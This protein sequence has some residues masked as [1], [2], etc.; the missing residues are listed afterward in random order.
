M[1]LHIQM[2]DEAL[3]KLKRDAMMSNVVSLGV[4]LGMLLLFGSILYFTVLIIQGEIPTEFIAYVPQSE[5]GPPTNAP[6]SRELTSK[7]VTTNP[8]VTPSVI[9]AQN[10]VGPVAA[11]VSIDTA[12]DLSFDQIDM[13][14]DMNLRDGLGTGGSGMGSGASGGSALEGTF[15]DLKLSRDGNSPSSI[16]RSE[17][18]KRVAFYKVSKRNGKNTY[19]FNVTSANA[20]YRIVERLNNFFNKGQRDALAPFYSSP[21]KLYASSFYVPMT[22]ASYA[23]HAYQCS[24]VCQ[25]AG[26]V[27]VYR[28]NVRAPKSGKFRFVGV[29]DDTLGVRFD[30]KVVLEAGYIILSLWEKDNIAGYKVSGDAAANNYWMK[31]RKGELPDKNGYIQIKTPETPTWNQELGGLTAGKVFEVKE[32]EVYPIQILVS[33]IPGGAFGYCLFIEDV[34]DMSA[35]QLTNTEQR[36]FDLFRTNF[37]SPDQKE[38]IDQ[39]RKGGA[40]LYGGRFQLPPF[41]PD[42]PIWAAVP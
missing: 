9:V 12:G 38:I 37:S 28:G 41:N 35:E 40:S 19:D 24:D 23:P 39:L 20:S 11:P 18:D 6:V 15:Y 29:G 31:V 21:Q 3:R 16:M 27:C 33:E 34:T 36:Q 7:S 14:M 1:S 10:A 32:G 30:N 17:Q 5:D 22:Q 8:N 25:P 4:C 26:W 2:S 42:S 13:S